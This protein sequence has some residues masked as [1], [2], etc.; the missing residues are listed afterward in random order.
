MTVLPFPIFNEKSAPT[1]SQPILSDVKKDFGM[2]PNL[3]GVMAKSPCLLKSYALTWSIFQKSIFDD[4]E[5]QVIYMTINFENNCEYCIPWHT[6][7]SELAGMAAE[8]INHLRCGESLSHTKLE[9]LHQFTKTMVRTRGSITPADLTGFF[10]AG[11]TEQ[12]ALEVVLGIAIKTMSNF[13]NAI[14]Q[15]P[16]DE[17]VK[18]YQWSKPSL[19]EN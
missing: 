11:Y 7:L 3:E 6:K 5:Q 18:Q 4:V 8:D 16:L 1:E 12:H 10:S 9:A 14:A 19:R 17:Q 2:I 15:T 13:T